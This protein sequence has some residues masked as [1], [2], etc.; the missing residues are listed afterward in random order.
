[1]QLALLP[2][3]MWTF[4]CVSHV[5]VSF[6]PWPSP[7]P[8][9]R[10]VELL[11]KLQR[12]NNLHLTLK[13]LQIHWLTVPPFLFGSEYCIWIFWQR[14]EISLLPQFTRWLVRWE[15]ETRWRQLKGNSACRRFIHYC[16]Y[17]N[18]YETEREHFKVCLVAAGC[19][20]NLF[21]GALSQII[22]TEQHFTSQIC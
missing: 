20:D 1:M 3:R 9:H 17:I 5:F 2:G 22:A 6:Q 19:S 15:T 21:A 16:A 4:P 11:R 14:T 18:L 8:T 10:S 12:E 13:A 7:S